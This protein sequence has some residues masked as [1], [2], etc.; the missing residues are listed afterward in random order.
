MMLEKSG[1][2]KKR[3]IWEDVGEIWSERKQNGFGS[4]RANSGSTGTKKTRYLKSK[5]LWIWEDA[6]EICKEGFGRSLE[7]IIETK[8][9]SGFDRNLQRKER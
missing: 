8:D 4:M 3:R 1:K 2:I 6:G 9:F 7:I 5:K